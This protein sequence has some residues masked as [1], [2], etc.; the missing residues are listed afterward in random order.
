MR[1]YSANSYNEVSRRVA[2]IISAQVIVNP[3]SV[4]GL[5][6][7]STPIG[8]YKQLIDWHKKGDLFFKDVIAINLDE[9]SGLKPE[10]PKSYAYF[11]RTN[12]F[13]FI[14]INPKNCFIPNGMAENKQKECERYDKIISEKGPIDLQLLGIGEN[15]H[16]GF[17][18]PGSAFELTTNLVKLKD[19]TRI[20]N[21]RFFDNIDQVP[22]F[23]FTMGIKAIMQAKTIL[24]VASGKNKADAIRKSFYGPVTPDVPASI[25]QLH[26]NVILVAD[27]DALN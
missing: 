20:A 27:T 25:L 5:A 13:D 23:A 3:E 11:M 22:S 2:N 26:S 14:D 9:Y 19:S 16:I 17:N 6:T 1:V 12:F 18:E 21:K 10:H 8:A 15:G 7:G 24:L 4:L